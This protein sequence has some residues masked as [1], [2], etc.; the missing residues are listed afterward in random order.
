QRTEA[1]AVLSEAV[2][3]T[4][5]A[6]LRTYGD[7]QQ[8]AAFFAQFEPGFE[9]LVEWNVRDGEVEA[10]VGAPARGARPPVLDHALMAGVD[11]RLSLSGPQG[12]ELRAEEAALQHRLAQLRSNAQALPPEAW[13]REEGRKLLAEYERARQRYSEVT[14]EI[15]NASPVYRRLAQPAF[16]ATLPALRARALGPK[17]PL[18]VYHIGRQRSYVLLVGD[19]AQAA[20]AFP[21]MVPA[22]VAR[23]VTSPPPPPLG[24]SLQ[25]KRGLVL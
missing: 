22:E 19:R 1:R 11:P 23:R 16:A 21:L 8:R 17:K 18:L 4:E 15:L 10:A 20:E 6:R 2:A 24:G 13:E 12:E 7:A 25:G 9:Q 3:V 5:R 14:R